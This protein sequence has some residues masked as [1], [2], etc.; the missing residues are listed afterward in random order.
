M[1]SLE[2]VQE[3]FRLALKHLYD[4]HERLIAID[5]NERSITHWLA[6]AVQAQF[7]DWTVDCEYNRK[8]E[9]PKNLKY[10]VER[11]S[12]HNTDGRSVYPDIIVHNRERPEN[13]LI[14]EIKKESSKEGPKKDLEKLAD[15]GSHGDYQYQFGVFAV[16]GEQRIFLQWFVEGQPAECEWL[17]LEEGHSLLVTT[18]PDEASALEL[19]LVHHELGRLGFN[20]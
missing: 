16:M 2:Q 9:L 11:V 18:P 19:Q 14:A 5:A 15:F 4:N 17:L 20:V 13:L 6:N 7:E 1:C 10:S 3:R 12:V 8:G